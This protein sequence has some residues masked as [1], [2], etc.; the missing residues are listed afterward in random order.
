MKLQD[1]DKDDIV[2]Q[3]IASL[4]V[5]PAVAKPSPIRLASGQVV[6]VD[7]L[8]AYLRRS[9]AEGAQ[10]S[11]QR[12]APYLRAASGAPG[13]AA[14]AVRSPDALC[15]QEAVFHDVRSYILGQLDEEPGA[16]QMFP[17][18]SGFYSALVAA[19][20]V[21][22]LD[23]ALF[24]MRRAPERLTSLLNNRPRNIVIY[25]LMFLVCTTCPRPCLEDEEAEQLFAASRSLLRF[26]AVSPAADAASRYHG[27]LRGLLRN[28]AGVADLAV[29]RSLVLRAWKLCCETWGTPGARGG[30]G[31]PSDVLSNWADFC[32]SADPGDVPS[33]LGGMIEREIA[34]AKMLHGPHSQQYA[35]ML[36]ISNQ[37]IMVADKGR[38]LIPHLNPK[39]IE[40]LT[41]VLRCDTTRPTRCNALAELAE[42]YRFRG[43][44]EV[45]V[46]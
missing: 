43:E 13:P 35:G 17:I 41:E 15:A 39:V 5:A 28:L 37:Y 33:D 27:P 22:K 3:V 29:F 23:E 2:R 18:W 6:N 10:L 14:L 45:A 30:Y 40:H 11:W 20:N 4:E 7:R 1:R 24:F 44:K 38:G 25:L 26:G 36:Y 9:R 42:A 16:G 31:A 34:N 46:K 21:G 12:I 8:T 19:L 32:G